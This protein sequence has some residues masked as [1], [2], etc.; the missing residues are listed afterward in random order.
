[1]CCVC[2]YTWKKRDPAP[3]GFG[4]SFP[5]LFSASHKFRCE[6]ASRD[7]HSITSM[8]IP[9]YT[10]AG[11]IRLFENDHSQEDRPSYTRTKHLLQMLE[12]KCHL[13]GKQM[14][15]LDTQSM[16]S[17]H[18]SRHEPITFNRIIHDLRCKNESGR[19]IPKRNSFP[20]VQ[21]DML[22]YVS[23]SVPG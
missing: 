6:N 20:S 7:W 16:P 21:D 17:S 4:L 15:S 14:R 19:S 3:A 13:L 1:M 10:H 23:Q 22:L 9:F 5:S 2:T 8:R 11:S 18:P 12:I